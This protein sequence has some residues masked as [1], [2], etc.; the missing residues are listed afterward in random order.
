MKGGGGEG[1]SRGERRTGRGWVGEAGVG[2]E[3]EVRGKADEGGGE[4]GSGR[5]GRGR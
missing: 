5:D 1:G 4:E 2:W 3:Q